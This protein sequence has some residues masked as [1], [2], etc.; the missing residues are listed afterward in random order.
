MT[1][2]FELQ[3]LEL[4]DK[5]AKAR[6]AEFARNLKVRLQGM[7]KVM[8]DCIPAFESNDV[9]AGI[10]NQDLDEAR[11]IAEMAEM[12]V[13][14][15]CLLR[16]EV[17]FLID[18]VV[19]AGKGHN[20]R[21]TKLSYELTG[22][23]SNK[24]GSVEH[25][26]LYRVAFPEGKREYNGAKEILCTPLGAK[27][28]LNFLAVRGTEGFIEGN[29]KQRSEALWSLHKYAM[30]APPAEVTLGLFGPV[31]K[32]GYVSE[33]WG[34][35]V[36]K[37]EKKLMVQD[38]GKLVFRKPDRPKPVVQKKL[39]R[40]VEPDVDVERKPNG[41]FAKGHRVPEEWKQQQAELTVGESK[42][43]TVRTRSYDQG[44]LRKKMLARHPVCPF[45]SIK[46]PEFLRV[47]HIKPDAECQ[48][49][50]G[51][52]PANILMLSIL[53]DKL[54]DCEGVDGFRRVAFITFNDEGKVMRSLKVT[55]E[56]LQALGLPKNWS[57]VS[58]AHLLEGPEG[59]RRKKFLKW[60]RENLFYDNV[61]KRAGK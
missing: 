18:G 9:T 42:E 32:D 7:P 36:A 8:H 10:T 29:V 25:Q 57:S 60:H 39:S 35:Y 55:N 23:F 2:D 38:D 41:Q 16:T 50:E 20:S 28:I 53:P 51:I 44:S 47:A 21:S 24:K 33:A 49:T 45:T 15:L 3:V 37:P 13:E 58:I 1:A 5:E 54:F 31:E 48:G 12:T 52:D 56:E 17:F 46:R 6:R 19:R 4:A 40:P 14:D 22:F 26:E 59:E 27:V 43:A 11:A 30:M 61:V 34:G